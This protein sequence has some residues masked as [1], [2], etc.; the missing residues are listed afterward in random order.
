MKKACLL[1]IVTLGVMVA[2]VLAQEPKFE[3]AS[4]M[5]L[6]NFPGLPDCA[7]GA[8]ANGDPTKGA[9][10]IYA[11]WP[12]GCAVPMHWHTA[13]EQLIAISGT[14]TVNHQG[15][16]APETVSKGGFVFMPAKHQHS[17]TCKT[18]CEFY[19]VTDGAFD[20]HYVD[21]SGNE[22]PPEQAFA[23]QKPAAG[24]KKGGTKKSNDKK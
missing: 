17:F 1:A 14:G 22:V 2:P 21:A 23:K 24:S 6:Q 10:V 9:G 5:K 18:A 16:S 13:N 7:K 19:I 8:V 11:K 3:P 4:Q 12:A 20:I 15:A